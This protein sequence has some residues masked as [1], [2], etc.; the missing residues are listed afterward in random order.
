MQIQSAS[1][2]ES[3]SEDEGGSGEKK[4]IISDPVPIKGEMMNTAQASFYL[5]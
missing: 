4:M 5:L 1:E 3:S 2:S